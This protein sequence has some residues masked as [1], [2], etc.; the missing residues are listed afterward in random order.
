MVFGLYRLLKPHVSGR[1]LNSYC[2]VITMRSE[3]TDRFIERQK[4]RDFPYIIEVLGLEIRVD[5]DVYP[6]SEDSTLLAE[7][8]ENES[9]GIKPNERTLDFGTG[10]GYFALVAARKGGNV[11]AVEVNPVSIQ[12]AM[13]NAQRNGLEERIEFR[14]GSFETISLEEKYDVVAA[15]LPFEAADPKDNFERGVYDKDFE[16]RREFFRRIKNHLTEN[17][18]IFFAYADYAE[19]VAPIVGF[20][21]GFDYELISEKRSSHGE[22]NRVYLITLPSSGALGNYR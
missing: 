5:R 7:E 19:K 16:T 11:V 9:Y 22:L 17:G 10:T 1:F 12:C 20:L 4:E 3:I 2:I 6:P 21:E 14:E 13:Y 15:S 18:R 8:L